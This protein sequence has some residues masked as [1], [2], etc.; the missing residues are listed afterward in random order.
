MGYPGCNVAPVGGTDRE[1]AML[2]RALR[3]VAVIQFLAG[4]AAVVGILVQ[5]TR[6]HV[7][8]DFN[9]LGIPICFGL[10]RLSSGW[11]IC[12]LAVLWP[13]LLFL[14]VMFLVGLVQE[15]PAWFG[16]FGVRLASVPPLWLAI[17]ALPLFV[18]TLWQYR[19]LTRPDIRPLFLRPGQESAG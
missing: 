13:G 3:G 2:P 19:V 16:V 15:R 17:A 14:P 7:N 1:K 5:L 9:V 4:L 10:R 6:S 11:R 18:I 12:A 8:I